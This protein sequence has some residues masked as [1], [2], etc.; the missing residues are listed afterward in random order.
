M[1]STV[2]YYRPG[3]VPGIYAV[4]VTLDLQP[5]QWANVDI[6]RYRDRGYHCGSCGHQHP[7][8]PLQTETHRIERYAEFR[9]IWERDMITIEIHNRELGEEA[10]YQIV[11][12]TA[13]HTDLR[14]MS[15]PCTRHGRTWHQDELQFNEIALVDAGISPPTAPAQVLE[16]QA[17]KEEA[18][19]KEINGSTQSVK[20]VYHV[21]NGFTA[22]GLLTIPVTS[23]KREQ[24][25]LLPLRRQEA[26]KHLARLN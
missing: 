20:S 19:I 8:D 3:G 14:A 2:T 23:Q 9:E 1:P 6:G 15:M 26:V 12:F 18:E 13:S 17:Q 10:P 4:Q 5:S 24:Q 21:R 25:I 11:V 22:H 7:I 16:E